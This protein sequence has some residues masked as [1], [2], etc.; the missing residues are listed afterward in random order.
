MSLDKFHLETRDLFEVDHILWTQDKPW[1]Q[2]WELCKLQLTI[3]IF[4]E[5]KLT[6][7]NHKE[8]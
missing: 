5:I 7:V 6:M 3:I 1:N 2:K 8:G 4:V